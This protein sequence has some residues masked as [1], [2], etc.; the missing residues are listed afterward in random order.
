[1]AHRERAEQPASDW[2]DNLNELQGDVSHDQKWAALQPADAALARNAVAKANLLRETDI[3][4]GDAYLRGIADAV[5]AKRRELL[6][7]DT[8]TSLRLLPESPDV[9]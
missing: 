2:P 7:E 6:I 3:D 4:A 8:L 1:M 9:D 5:H